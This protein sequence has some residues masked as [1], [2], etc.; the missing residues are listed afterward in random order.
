MIIAVD[1]DSELSEEDGDSDYHNVSCVNIPWVWNH[2]GS[3][4]LV[5]K[6]D[7]YPVLYSISIL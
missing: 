6:L 1:S 3:H 5:H 4:W 7:D 2:Q